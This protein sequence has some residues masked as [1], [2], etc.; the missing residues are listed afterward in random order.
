MR[1]MIWR[2]P[3]DYAVDD[4]ADGIHSALDGGSGVPRQRGDG[5]VAAE[6]RRDRR[7]VR[8]VTVHGEGRARGAAQRQRVGHGEGQRLTLVHFSD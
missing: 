7:G 5:G 2:A 6:T 1:R 4:V 3:V 8:G